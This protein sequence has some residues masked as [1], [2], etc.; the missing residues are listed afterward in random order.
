MENESANATRRRTSET[1]GDER[2]FALDAGEKIGYLCA[3]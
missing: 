3:E 2:F 1:G